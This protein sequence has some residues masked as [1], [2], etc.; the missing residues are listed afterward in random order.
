MSH[1]NSQKISRAATFALLLS[2]TALAGCGDGVRQS[3][4]TKDRQIAF[5]GNYYKAKA[6]KVSRDVRDH[7][8]VDVARA[9]QGLAGAKQAGAHEAKRYC[10]EEF[11]TSKINWIVG[12]D[13]ESL[14]PVDDK[15]KL[16]GTCRT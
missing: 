12:P 5:E 8:T 13:T 2:A 14:F 11:G 1:A 6:N 3:F 10:I 16:E 15:L 7:F 4:R 9:N